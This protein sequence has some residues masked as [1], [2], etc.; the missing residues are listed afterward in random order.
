MSDG[1][2]V[3]PGAAAPPVEAPPA[4]PATE[5]A[6]PAAPADWRAGFAEDVRS[7][8]VT[9]RLAGPEAALR[10]LIGA[11]KMIGADKIVMPG[12]DAKPEELNEFYTKLGRPATSEDYDLSGVAIP[13]N[14]AVDDAFQG[15]A[16]G[17]MHELGLTQAQV[18]GVL[19][20]YYDEVGGQGASRAT[21]LAQNV[22]AGIQALKTEW[23]PAYRGKADL[24]MR[25]F[26]AGAG[27]FAKEIEAAETLD[28]V[29]LGDH[30]AFIRVFATLGAQMS[31]HGLVGTATTSSTLAPGEAKNAR[32][33]L[34]A[35][36]KFKEAFL[37]GTH[38]E[39]DA[40]VQR[41]ADL[42]AAEVGAE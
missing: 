21:E 18:D 8:P 7:N 22:E 36:P 10:E 14:V 23:G 31:E 29:Q 12:K 38:L 24:A 16:V 9:Q 5:V 33:K 41:I 34:L 3:D 15:A 20:M 30:P 13:E 17:K 1:A 4:V 39:H 2:V 6:T 28:G 11:Q 26:R 19:N 42:T 27:E 37:S 40:A 32:L 25:A 35:D